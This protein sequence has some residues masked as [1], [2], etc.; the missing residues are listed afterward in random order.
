MG[1]LTPEQ[2]LAEVRYAVSKSLYNYSDN[3]WFSPN[4][5]V[6]FSNSFKYK[7]AKLYKLGLLERSP[8]DGYAGRWGYFYRFVAVKKEL[9]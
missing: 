9:E 8:E 4:D 2:M 1:R 3:R 5:V 7:C 6:S